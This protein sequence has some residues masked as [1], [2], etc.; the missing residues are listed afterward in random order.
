MRRYP[1][2]SFLFWQVPKEARD[3][4][5]AYRFLNSVKE[6]GNRAQHVRIPGDQE[7]ICVLDGQQRLTSLYVGFQGTYNDRRTKSGKGSKTYVEKKL[8]LNLLHDGRIPDP[9]NWQNTMTSN[10]LIISLFWKEMLTGLRL[11]A[12]SG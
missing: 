9:N 1:I 8:F 12:S 6:W 5:E 3:D 4:I 10:S 7:L 2:S 11:D